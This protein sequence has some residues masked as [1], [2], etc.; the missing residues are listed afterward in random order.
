MW[1]GVDELPH[2]ERQEK[3]RQQEKLD[4]PGRLSTNIVPSTGPPSRFSQ[5][6]HAHCQSVFSDSNTNRSIMANHESRTYDKL[7]HHLLAKR[8]WST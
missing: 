2:E 5:K 3:E 4:R 6:S 8:L 1:T 7:W